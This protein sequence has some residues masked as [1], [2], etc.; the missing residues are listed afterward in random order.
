MDIENEVRQS[1]KVFGLLLGPRV[2][3]ASFVTRV[4]AGSA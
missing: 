1:L 3:R 2:P 4:R